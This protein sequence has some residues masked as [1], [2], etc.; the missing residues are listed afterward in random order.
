MATISTL[1]NGVKVATLRNGLKAARV[2]VYS[3]QGS[4]AESVATAGHTNLYSQCLNVAGGVNAKTT[5]GHTQINAQAL[6]ASAALGR[7][8]GA[9]NANVTANLDAAR[10]AADAQA[11]ALDNDLWALSKEYA[12][13]TG[14]QGESLGQPVTGS[15][16][17]IFNATAD[18][19]AAKAG[20]LLGNGLCVVAVGD[21][22]HA[23]FADEVDKAFGGLAQKYSHGDQ[24]SQ[25]FSGSLYR[26]RFDS[27]GYCC[28]TIMQHAV[29]EGHKDYMSLRVANQTIGD[30]C[31]SE[32]YGQHSPVNLK[33]RLTR[34]PEYASAMASFYDSFAANATFGVTLRTEG[35]VGHGQEAMR[36]IQNF[37][38]Q[39]ST[40]T[41]EFEVVAAKNA[42]LLKEAQA[43]ETNPVDYIGLKVLNTGSAPTIQAVKTGLDA[44]TVKSVLNACSFWLYDQEIAGGMVGCTDGMLQGYSLRALTAH[45]IPTFKALGYNN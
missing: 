34:R 21:V 31:N 43:A 35:E 17:T 44:V 37:W 19:V 25:L 30:F 6:T 39:R 45:Q 5:R 40:R 32:A 23:A 10:A 41:T 2:G 14:F 13:K 9:M 20:T 33:R 15:T 29:P 26:H 18:E 8:T 24:A 22:D 4:G 16:D 1:A 7:I 3:G 12:Y 38:A 27:M 42:I 36:R 28:T 11:V